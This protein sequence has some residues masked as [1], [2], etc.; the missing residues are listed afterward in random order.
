M[1]YEFL[2]CVAWSGY[3]WFVIDDAYI[4]VP[5]LLGLTASLVQLSLFV[6]YG[7]DKATPKG[8]AA[9]EGAALTG[10]KAV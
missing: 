6:V 5:N 3:G 2:C 1:R 9:V 10:E 8:P 4:Y 7:V